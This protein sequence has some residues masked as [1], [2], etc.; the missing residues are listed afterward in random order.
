MGPGIII[1]LHIGSLTLMDIVCH[2]LYLTLVP[3]LTPAFAALMFIRSS[4]EQ[5]QA[6]K[7]QLEALVQLIAQ[8]LQTIDG[9]Y[10][11]G[12]LLQV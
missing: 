9:E 5:V 10:C 7:S 12:Q 11:A 3:C 4:V 6:S 2:C 8:L 1:D